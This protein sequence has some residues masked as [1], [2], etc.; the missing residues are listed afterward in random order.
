MILL[1]YD[2]ME[3]MQNTLLYAGDAKSSQ[4]PGTPMS[5][6]DEE[7]NNILNSNIA[8]ERDKW[9]RYSQL[10]QRYLHLKEIDKPATVNEKEDAQKDNE[11]ID[12]KIIATI[13]MKYR[14]KARHLLE[15]LR[16]TEHLK[17][18]MEK[19]YIDGVL[20]PG[21]NI[22]DL[23]NDATRNRKTVSAPLGHLQ[24]AAALQRAHIPKEF[25]GNDR[26]WK[27]IIGS[28]NALGS[29]EVIRSS[30]LSPSH[31]RNKRV[32]NSSTSS[33]NTRFSSAISSTSEE[34]DTPSRKKIK[35]K[36]RSSTYPRPSRDF[37]KAF[38]SSPEKEKSNEW[39]RMKFF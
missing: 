39:L 2:S 7:M 17:F 26:V 5:R 13:P 35:R 19:V 14:S 27:N 8:D 6:L 38:N 29:P 33:S 25:I 32:F 18:N 12:A 37:R 22:I 15:G 11:D 36:S 20:L 10:L 24:F 34:D 21:G 31:E 23:I 1:P 30:A 16:E 9:A 28:S 4:T 3:R